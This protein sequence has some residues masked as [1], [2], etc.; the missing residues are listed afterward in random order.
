[1]VYTRNEGEAVRTGFNF[2]PLKG[3]LIGVVLKVGTFTFTARYNK[4]TKKWVLR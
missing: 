1:M 3:N 2:Y 4:T